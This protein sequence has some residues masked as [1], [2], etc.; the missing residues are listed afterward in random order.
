[1]NAQDIRRNLNVHETFARRP[2]RLLNVQF[3]ACSQGGILW[4]KITYNHGLDEIICNGKIILYKP[5][6]SYGDGL[7]CHSSAVSVQ[8]QPLEVFYKK[9]VLNIFAKFTGIHQCQS[10]FFN[11]V[12]GLSL[13]FYLKETLVEGFFCEFCESFKIIFFQRALLDDCF[14]LYKNNWIWYNSIQ[15]N[16]SINS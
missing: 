9:G 1:M 2:G 14:C 7:M 16:S 4:N 10:L 8:I 5:V 15:Y 11:K 6:T 13:Q 3:T 12:R